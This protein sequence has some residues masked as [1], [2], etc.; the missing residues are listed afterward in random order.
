MK[1]WIAAHSIK[2]RKHPL[3]SLVSWLPHPPLTCGSGLPIMSP[4]Q[5][6]V[7]TPTLRLPDEDSAQD[8]DD[9]THDAR[10]VPPVGLIALGACQ[11]RPVAKVGQQVRV[12]FLVW[13]WEHGHPQPTAGQV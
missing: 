8:E 11:D 10:R 1:T 13:G 4:S 5:R 12:A 9:K 3:L 6:P 2:L 7:P